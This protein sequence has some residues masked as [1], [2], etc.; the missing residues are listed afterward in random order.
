MKKLK[1]II[2]LIIQIFTSGLLKAQ[3]DPHF[4]QYYANPLWLNPALTGAINGEERVIANFKDQWTSIDNGYKTGAL[5]A[6]YR[7]SEKVGLGFNILNQA[8]GTAGYN[9]FAGYISFGYKIAVSQ[10]EKKQLHFGVQAGIINRSFDPSKVQADDQYNPAIGFDP[11]LPSFE[12]YPTTSSTAFDAAAGIFYNDVDETKSANFFGGISAAHLTRE[13]DPFASGGINST[14]P[15]RLTVHAGI[16]IK[17]SEDFDITPHLLY[18]RQQQNQL[19]AI[20]VY[21]ELKADE[22][23]GLILGGLYRVNDAA[24]I[25]AGYHLNNML[26]G[27]SYDFNTS[28]LHAATNY[29]GGLELSLTYVFKGGVWE[30]SSTVSPGF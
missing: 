4:S 17:A 16:K 14:L 2:T 20:G 9:Y 21:S 23:H 28:A 30:N 26:I 5:S 24:V 12:N 27:L 6:D 10:D 25:N 8:A 7:P 3:V 22:E 11:S 15:I 13:K 29:Q 1:V 18:I 19:R